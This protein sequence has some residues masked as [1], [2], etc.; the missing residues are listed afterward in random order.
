MLKKKTFHEY[1]VQRLRRPPLATP[2]FFYR[3]GATTGRLLGLGYIVGSTCTASGT[4]VMNRMADDLSRDLNFKAA[5]R[6][7]TPSSDPRPSYSSS[8]ILLTTEVPGA[9]QVDP[10]VFPRPKSRPVVAP[11]P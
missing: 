8:A 4:C 1:A 6:Q 11:D 7:R 3:S 10:T 9:T 5:V 2:L